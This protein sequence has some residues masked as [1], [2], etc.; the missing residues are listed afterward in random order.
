MSFSAEA[1]LRPVTARE[2]SDS[3]ERNP[4]AVRLQEQGFTPL[5]FELRLLRED[6]TEVEHVHSVVWREPGQTA[7][8]LLEE[9]A[10]HTLDEATRSLRDFEGVEVW[11]ED[12]E[13][14]VAL[15]V[16]PAVDAGTG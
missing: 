7:A 10:A 3:F 5:W 9:E 16:D 13:G 14:A 6:G 11:P 8:A 1:D 2:L 4:G 15:R 12:L